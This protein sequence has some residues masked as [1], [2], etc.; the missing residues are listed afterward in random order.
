M[1]RPWQVVGNHG[2][3]E[4]VRE[5]VGRHAL[6]LAHR[7]NRVQ[8][9]QRI[10]WVPVVL[11]VGTIFLPIVNFFLLLN[12]VRIVPYILPVF[13]IIILKLTML[14][15]RLAF[16]EFLLLGRLIKFVLCADVGQLVL[17]LFLVLVLK[18]LQDG[19]D[20]IS[21][22]SLHSHA[23]S[24]VLGDIDLL[25]DVGVHSVVLS[26]LLELFLGGSEDIDVF[27]LL[28][29][30]QLHTVGFLLEHCF[31]PSTFSR[32]QADSLK[33]LVFQNSI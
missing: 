4:T 19:V 2:R 12:E 28:A 27:I 11:L 22:A 30:V 3:L 6:F 31:F 26:G 13:L 16:P 20:V 33:V 29:S 7:L 32:M 15:F 25:K 8:R 18:I 24:I 17:V 23:R 14:E 9:P 21:A 1:L 5:F 10:Q